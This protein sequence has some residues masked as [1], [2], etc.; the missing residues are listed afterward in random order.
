MSSTLGFPDWFFR[1]VQLSSFVSPVA[2]L[3]P[4]CVEKFL[5]WHPTS[6]WILLAWDVE[7]VRTSSAFL[8]NQTERSQK[9]GKRSPLF[10]PHSTS[11]MTFARGLMCSMVN[12]D[13]IWW[14]STWWWATFVCL[15]GFEFGAVKTPQLQ[16]NSHCAWLTLYPISWPRHSGWSSSPI[17]PSAALASSRGYASVVMPPLSGC[18]LTAFLTDGRQVRH[19]SF[20]WLRLP[21]NTYVLVQDVS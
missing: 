6:V 15:G 9:M 1:A 13:C 5:V 4:P 8:M 19:W 20:S 7:L 14:Y 3:F 11:A 12:G 18:A 2:E 10:R 21:S 16:P 17:P